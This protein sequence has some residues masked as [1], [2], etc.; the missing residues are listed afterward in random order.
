MSRTFIAWRKKERINSGSIKKMENLS[1]G[2]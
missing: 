1:M 2:L